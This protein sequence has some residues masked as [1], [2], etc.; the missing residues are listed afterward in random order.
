MSEKNKQFIQ[1]F[2][3]LAISISFAVFITRSGIVHQFVL[4]LG[5]WKY[6]GIFAAGIFFTSIFTV[7]PSVVIL[8]DFAQS[9]P[10]FVIGVVGGLGAA[11]GDFVIFRLVKDRIADDLEFLLLPSEK[12]RI[13]KIIHTRFVRFF[14]PLIG[15]LIIAAPLPDEMGVAI[16]GMSK[17]SNKVFLPLSFVLNGAGILFV[18]WIATNIHA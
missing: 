9:T 6:L 17:L 5:E 10:L 8:G 2:I 16:L 18:S 1:D 4:S 14:A 12:K 11:L 3:L 7:A 15:A 13:V